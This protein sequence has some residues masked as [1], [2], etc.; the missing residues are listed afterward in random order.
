MT[1]TGFLDA[2]RMKLA[3]TGASGFIGGRLIE[4]LCLNGNIQPV[5]VLRASSPRQ[6]LAAFACEARIADFA[7][8]ASLRDALSGCDALVH[9][10]FD[11]SPPDRAGLIE[12]NLTALYNTVRAAGDTGIQRFVYLSSAAVYGYRHRG[13]INETTPY[14]SEPDPYAEAKQKCE[15]LLDMLV[16][17]SG[18]ATVILQPGIVYGPRAYWTTSFAEYA[19]KGQVA[20]PDNGLGI[21]NAVY[22]DDVIETIMAALAHLPE[23]HLQRY[24]VVGPSACTW[25]EYASRY[26]QTCG[27]GHVQDWAKKDRQIRQ[28]SLLVS[29]LRNLYTPIARNPR[30]HQLLKP[31]ADWGYKALMSAS[32]P[33]QNLVPVF[34]SQGVYDGTKARTELSYSAQFSLEEGMALT[35]AWLRFARLLCEDKG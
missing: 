16:R 24:L 5:A 3:V 12:Q 19:R 7:E 32:L 21:C 17:T 13:L 34:A 27:Q 1:Q 33:G 4:W 2:K 10:A 22:V 31:V 9:C 11:F 29:G 26:L 18:P 20:L 35:I 23:A 15:T 25:H 28:M 8:P 30:A 14:E 6:F